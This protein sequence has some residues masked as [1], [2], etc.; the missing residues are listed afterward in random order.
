MEFRPAEICVFLVNIIDNS[1]KAG[2]RHL[3]IY[4]DEK[5][6]DFKDDGSGLS[7][8]ISPVDLFRKGLTT[9]SGSGLG[10]YHCKM[11]AKN[12]NAELAIKNNEN[13]VGITLTMGFK[14]EN[15]I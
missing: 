14:N 6:L 7:P 11:I 3:E 1:R 4:C 12:I 13:D 5:G 15:G 9:T 10:L 2:A 8:L